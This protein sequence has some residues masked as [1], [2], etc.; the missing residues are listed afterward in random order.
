MGVKPPKRMC[1]SCGREITETANGALRPHKLPSGGSCPAGNGV[2]ATCGRS[3]PLYPDG[4]VRPHKQLRVRLKA[5]SRARDGWLDKTVEGET[6]SSNRDCPGAGEASEPV[7][8][9]R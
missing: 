7:G 1:P 6:Y 5:Q 2:C 9:E 3:A 8:V 4:T